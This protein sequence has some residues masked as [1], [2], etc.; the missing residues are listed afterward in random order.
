M[1][2]LRKNGGHPIKGDPPK[3]HTGLK[4]CA[5]ISRTRQVGFL[6]PC[7]N[8]FQKSPWHTDIESNRVQS[9]NSGFDT[10]CCSCCGLHILLCF[11]SHL[12]FPL[13]NGSNGLNINVYNRDQHFSTIF[14]W[15]PMV[16]PCGN[17][18]NTERKVRNYDQTNTYK[19]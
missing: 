8:L 15:L 14:W 5:D 4:L 7:V 16:P 3:S 10:L 6:S 2:W 17:F 12:I 1:K 11:C 18:E 19:N 13:S 9:T